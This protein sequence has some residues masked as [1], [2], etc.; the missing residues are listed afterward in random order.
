MHSY[1]RTVAILFTPSQVPVLE[2]VTM[3]PHEEDTD[4]Q[5]CRAV[6]E[7]PLHADEASLTSQT[8]Q[9]GSISF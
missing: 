7:A 8:K 2:Q 5:S 4:N 6:P 1:L 9:I 3:T